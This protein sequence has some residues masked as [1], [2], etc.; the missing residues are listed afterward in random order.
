MSLSTLLM[1][2]LY[3]VSGLISLSVF[4]ENALITLSAFFPEGFAL[5]AVLLFGKRM[6]S[7]I[8]LGQFILA[9]SL[10]FSFSVG[11]EIGLSNT[12]EA[13]I[14]Y[15]L[16]NRFKL[17]TSLANLKDVFGLLA[18]IILL[19]QPFS[20]ILGNTIL[21][22]NGILQPEAFTH[23]LFYWWIGNVLGQILLT[24]MLLILY[25]E[26]HKLNIKEI[27]LLIAVTLLVNYI[28]QITFEVKNVSLLLIITLPMTI[29]LS[30]RNLL[31]ASISSVV[32]ASISLYFAHHGIGTF[33]H[34]ESMVD[35][36]LDLNYFMFSHILLVL[37]VGVL[38]Q[39]KEAAIQSLKNMAHYDYLTGLPNRHILREEIHHTVA[40]AEEYQA[41]GAVC[42]IDLD[43]FKPIN[44]DY[45][46]LAG[47]ETLKEV[48]RRLKR[49]V[50]TKDSL[51]RIGGDEFLI[52]L[53][54]IESKEAV[55]KQLD[56][57]VES[58]HEP[59]CYGSKTF[60]ISFSIGVSFCPEDGNTV[61][62]LMEKADK[63][64]YCAKERGKN[65]VCFADELANI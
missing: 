13:Y 5:A 46:H 18:M 60:H 59:I 61:K 11:L 42:F 29:Y 15:T 36:L 24:P 20:A 39:E 1:A 16:F 58:M 10:G 17:H 51:L 65:Q 57:L 34:T 37:L 50:E 2:L 63:A 35:N 62:A 23:S 41:I 8:F 3:Y 43:N 9:L 31:Y 45:G 19:L 32:L 27:V 49:F 25:H 26:R 14:A 38:F 64:M 44:D 54:R 48:T 21:Y 30:T 22:L 55:K 6:L 40:L 33:S 7:G 52:I 47:D 53:N 28:V 4:N 12:L 56:A